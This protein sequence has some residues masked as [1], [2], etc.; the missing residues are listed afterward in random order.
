MTDSM[1]DSLHRASFTRALRNNAA[2]AMG[3]ALSLSVVALSPTAANAGGTRTWEVSEFGEF[4]AGETEGAAI[5]SAGRVSVG[6]AAE[7]IAVPG[8]TA[9]SCLGRS[10]EVWIGTADK[11]AIQR[12]VNPKRKK[13]PPKIELVAELSGIAVTAMVE[14]PGG[15]VVAATL[16]GGKLVRVTRRGKV[17]DFAELPVDQIWALLIADGKLLAAT[18]PKGELFSLTLSGG[19]PKVVLDVSDKHLLSLAKVGKDVVVGT[20][21]GA[22]LYA[23]SDTTKGTLLH[24]FSGDEVRAIALTRTGLLAAV[25]EFEDRKLTSVDALTKTLNR[26]SLVGQPASGSS[27]GGTAPKADAKV[28]HVDLGK[29]RDLA[30]AS[31]APWEQWL[32]HDGQYFTSML[33][34]DDV[35][36]VLVGSS[37]DGKV[38]RLRGPRTASTVADF[39]ERQTT[40]LCRTDKGSIFATTGGSA[41][42]YRLLA[43][44]A[45]KARYRTKVFKAKQPAAYGSLVVRG[46]SLVSARARVGPSDKPDKRWSDWTDVTIAKSAGALRGTLSGLPHRRY[47]Q[48]EFVL[49]RPDSEVRSIEIFYA[50]ENLAPL[51]REVEFQRPKFAQTDSDEPSPNVT[52]K[53]KADARDEDKLVYDVRVR[54]E[55]GSDLDWV[56]LHPATKRVTKRE[57][58][59]DLTTVPNGVYEVEVIAS[60]EPSNGSGAALVD[61][62]T[63]EPFVVDR[64]RPKVSD[65]KLSGRSGR[66]TAR[67]NATHI[68]DVAFAIDGGD[69]SPA[70]AEDGLFDTPS[71]TVVFEIPA[72]VARGRHRLVVRA[73]DGY[74]NIGTTALFFDL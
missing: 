52:I 54:P 39:E 18:G 26:T 14:L 3:I 27:S 6:F 8:A 34:L 46:K 53:W 32:A 21:P 71:E 68:H 38:Y 58:K 70:T 63:S 10:N 1:T 64:E 23:V 74:G 50:P 44:A 16:P 73:R 4:D 42:A 19:D 25:N 40:A 20:S 49:E 72:A 36:T 48:L 11:A 51:V 66:A 55:G 45:K 67:D 37:A 17:S 29:D 60:D 24:D 30:R 59:W 2:S 28:F 7:R 12:V 41:A 56:N 43:T 13:G 15:D 65:I 62:L 35:G 57:L 33:A 9:F 69:F 5:E 22:K 31:E 61:E 47:L